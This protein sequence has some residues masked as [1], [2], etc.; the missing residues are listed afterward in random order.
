MAHSLSQG[1]THTRNHASIYVLV[2][3]LQSCLHF[4]LNSEEVFFNATRIFQKINKS[5]TF[6]KIIPC[7]KNFKNIFTRFSG[8]S[9]NEA[10]KVYVVLERY[11][12]LVR[13]AHQKVDSPVTGNNKYWC[14]R[15][16]GFIGKHIVY[17][18]RSI[19]TLSQQWHLDIG[20]C[21]LLLWSPNL[22]RK[23]F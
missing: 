3:C 19:D 15:N 2:P 20:A 8:A 21:D 1:S 11:L 13:E 14:H 6:S 23:R 16:A 5:W 22:F 10:G 7:C 9:K 18:D 17:P 12:F 4:V